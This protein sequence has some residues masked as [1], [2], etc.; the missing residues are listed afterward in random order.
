MP[1]RTRGLAPEVTSGTV[2][3]GDV[4][5]LGMARIVSGGFGGSRD[6]RLPVTRLPWQ[7]ARHGRARPVARRTGARGRWAAPAPLARVRRTPDR[8]G[9]LRPADA[10]LARPA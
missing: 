9:L 4:V 8:R 10:G 6:T 3:S 7:G 1:D 5:A 2:S